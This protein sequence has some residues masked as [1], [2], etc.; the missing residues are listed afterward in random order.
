MYFALQTPDLKAAQTI[1]LERMRLKKDDTIHFRQIA[2][3]SLSRPHL[4]GRIRPV[5]RG[6]G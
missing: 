5:R 2:G 6:A 3:P 4:D 1:T